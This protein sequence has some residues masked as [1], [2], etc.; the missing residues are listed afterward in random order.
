MDKKRNKNKSIADHTLE[1]LEKRNFIAL[2][3]NKISIDQ[4]LIDSVEG[5]I[6]YSPSMSDMILASGVR[7]ERKRTTISVTSESTLDCVRRLKYEGKEGVLCLNFASA[8]NPG[9]GFLGGSQG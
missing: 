8:R 7:G 9:G 4:E 1:I 2:D 3:G 5:T 6:C